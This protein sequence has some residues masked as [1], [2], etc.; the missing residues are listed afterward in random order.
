MPTFTS[1]RRYR[2][3]P[4]RRSRV[5]AIARGVAMLLGAAVACSFIA[6]RAT[7]GAGSGDAIL[8]GPNPVTAGHHDEWTLQYHA[9]QS[10]AARGVV[11]IDIPP[12][13]SPPQ[14]SDSIAPGYFQ[15][16]GDPS[17]DSVA[18]SGRTIRVHLSP[19]FANDSYFWIYYGIGGGNAYAHAQT[20]AQDSVFFHV[21]SD[22]QATGTPQGL[23]SSPF[24]SVVADPVVVS[25]DIVDASGASVE[26]GR[27]HV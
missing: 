16:L 18:V 10:F 23:A 12:G 17:I 15:C 5:R 14:R 22:P 4:R 27:A 24:L 26:I 1:R 8:F 20:A 11:E 3:F 25:A 9:T 6:A 19:P 2:A 21:R 7:A 13:W